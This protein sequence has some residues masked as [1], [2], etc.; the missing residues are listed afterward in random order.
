MGMA[1]GPPHLLVVATEREALDALE[2]RLHVV[3][4]LGILAALAIIVVFGVLAVRRG[5]APL[6]SFGRSLSA[7]VAAD[8]LAASAPPGAPTAEPGAQVTALPAELIPI[9]QVAQ[10][11]ID[12]ALAALR[13]EQR[14]ARVAAHELRTPLAEIRLIAQALS[15]A[16]AEREALLQVVDAMTRAVDALLTLARYEAGIE[17][18][19]LEPVDLA[20]L[21]RQALARLASTVQQR[22]LV[23]VANLPAEAWTMSDAA[24]LERI[25]ANVLGNAVVHAPAA[26]R[27]TASLVTSGGQVTLSVRN[28]ARLD[29]ARLRGRGARRA[30]RGARAHGPGHAGLGLLAAALARHSPRTRRGDGRRR[31]RGETHGLLR[32]CLTMTRRA[33]DGLTAARCPG[34]GCAASQVHC[35]SS[36]SRT[37]ACGGVAVLNAK[38]RSA[39]AAVWGWFD[40][41][42]TNGLAYHEVGWSHGEWVAHQ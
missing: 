26:T 23:V 41:L 10:R 15:A 3:L 13:R 19:A 16:H 31:G 38:R 4:V 20:A 27:L 17:M 18:P 21:V 12:D 30:A 24:M 34:H 33:A 2:Q 8:A 29:A 9:A 22:G 37:R 7:R 39:S 6:E 40:R 42:T 32:R 25:L 28:A 36:S 14:F 11:A 1:R 5:L 35:C